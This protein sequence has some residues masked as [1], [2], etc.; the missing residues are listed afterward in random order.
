MD[1]S[2]EFIRGRFP[3]VGVGTIFVFVV[4]AAHENTVVAVMDVPCAYLRFT[5][6]SE[7]TLLK[8]S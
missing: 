1:N 5:Y 6:K 7:R 8:S 4:D 3:T 2:R